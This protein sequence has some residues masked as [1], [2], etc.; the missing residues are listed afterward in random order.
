MKIRDVK[1]QRWESLFSTKASVFH[2]GT[3]TA[4][5]PG[6]GAAARGCPARN[7]AHGAWPRAAGLQTHNPIPV[8][9]YLGDTKHL[10]EVIRV[11]SWGHHWGTSQ[12]SAER[13]K[14]GHGKDMPVAAGPGAGAQHGAEHPIS[15]LLHVKGC[16]H[17][18]AAPHVPDWPDQRCP[19]RAPHLPTVRAV[20]GWAERPGCILPAPHPAPP[21]AQAQGLS[22]SFPPVPGCSSRGWRAAG[23]LRGRAGLRGSGP[24]PSGVPLPAARGLCAEPRVGATG[25]EAE[26]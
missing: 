16:P 25:A 7:A 4:A 15:E 5:Q 26:S 19:Q 22:S 12:C 20:A 9:W 21:A 1:G 6:M 11:P 23:W 3:W 10:L 18:W 14:I 13:G 8:A 2:S 24:G 17:Q